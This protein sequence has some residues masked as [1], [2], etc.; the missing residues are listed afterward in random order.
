MGTHSYGSI[1]PHT[2]LTLLTLLTPSPR[3][4]HSPPPQANE[5][6]PPES[7]KTEISQRVRAWA[8]DMHGRMDFLHALHLERRRHQQEHKVSWRAVP[9]AQRRALEADMKRRLVTA[10]TEALYASERDGVAITRELYAKFEAECRALRHSPALVV[11]W[12]VWL[13]RRHAKVETGIRRFKEDQASRAKAC[14]DRQSRLRTVA[15]LVEV[16]AQLLKVRLTLSLPIFLSL[17]LCS[18]CF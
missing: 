13:G 7:M 11:N 9:E 18:L 14:Q 16:E 17:S 2:L 12:G 4:P 6:I 3:S 8:L 1:P 5:I 10:K 15:P